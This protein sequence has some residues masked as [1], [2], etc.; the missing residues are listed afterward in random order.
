MIWT[1]IVGAF[2]A[3]ARRSPAGDRATLPKSQGMSA[4][5]VFDTFKSLV[6]SWAGTSDAGRVVRVTYSLHAKGSVLMEAW[7]LGPTSDALT[8]YRIDLDDLVATHYCPLGNQPRL[9]LADPAATGEYVFEFHSAE[10]VPDLGAA[11]QH[12]FALRLLGPDSFWRS[13]TYTE[14]ADSHTEAITYYREG[15]PPLETR[16]ASL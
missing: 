9:I 8:L 16:K 14:G 10:N 15:E 11:H 12:A 2:E 4:P 1:A 6:G 5:Q 7:H 3:R 13:E